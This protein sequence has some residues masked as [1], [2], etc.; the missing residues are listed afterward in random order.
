MHGRS[1][2]LVALLLLTPMSQFI[3]ASA[4]SSG[5]SMACNGDIC[6]SEVMPNPNGYDNA[7]WPGGEWVELHNTGTTD[8][9]ILYCL[10]ANLEY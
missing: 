4:A 6:L 5:R 2:F 10:V 3:D 9:S 8:I 1:I 7:S